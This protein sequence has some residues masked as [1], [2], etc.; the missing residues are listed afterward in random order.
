MARTNSD[1]YVEASHCDSIPTFFFSPT[2]CSRLWTFDPGSS[3]LLHVQMNY[4][5]YIF[6]PVL[7]PT[8]GTV[9]QAH[10]VVMRRTD[11][12]RSAKQREILRSR[13]SLHSV[14]SRVQVSLMKTTEWIMSGFDIMTSCIVGQFWSFFAASNK[15]L[16]LKVLMPLNIQSYTWE[17]SLSPRHS[18]SV[19]LYFLCFSSSR[20]LSHLDFLIFHRLSLP[21]ICHFARLPTFYVPFPISPT[22]P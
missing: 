21:Y 19:L 15:N 1:L 18:T 8:D 20:L 11:A 16:R 22:C 14:R 13:S 6:A 4:R 3:T 7:E 10:K 17:G 2:R 9:D 12:V 5:S